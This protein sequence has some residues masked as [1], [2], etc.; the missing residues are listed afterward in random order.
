M[1]EIYND[2]VTRVGFLRT[3]DVTH[4]PKRM[5]NDNIQK[6]LNKEVEQFVQPSNVPQAVTI[7]Q[8]ITYYAQNA[9][10]DKTNLYKSTSIWLLDYLELKAERVKYIAH[11]LQSKVEDKQEPSESE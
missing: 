11:Q 1:S 10:G 3:Q 9:E 7:E 6:H 4:K 5:Q 8:A 2:S